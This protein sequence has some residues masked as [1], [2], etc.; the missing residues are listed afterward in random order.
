MLMSAAKVI[1]EIKDLTPEQQV[2]VIRFA[3]HL[4]RTRPLTGEELSRLA[5][6]MV[7]SNDPGEVQRIKTAITR[8]FY[9]ED[10]DA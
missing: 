4:A 9:G 7:E 1:E 2:E 8:G 6:R 10:P 5:T 3:F